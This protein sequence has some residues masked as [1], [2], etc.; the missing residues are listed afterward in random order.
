MG[1]DRIVLAQP[2]SVRLTD[3]QSGTWM[4]IAWDAGSSSVTITRV[5]RRPPSTSAP[6]IVSRMLSLGSPSGQTRMVTAARRRHDRAKFAAPPN[7]HRLAYSRRSVY[8]SGDVL[9]NERKASFRSV[10]AR[11]YRPRHHMLMC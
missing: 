8:R 3:E 2:T 9:V 7:V 6:P 1:P 4:I 5:R 11:Q 10:P